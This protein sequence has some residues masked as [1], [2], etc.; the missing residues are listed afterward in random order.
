VVQT[1]CEF[2]AP[3]S[4][5]GSV[6]VGIRVGRIGNSSVRYELGIFNGTQLCAYGHFVHV[7]VDSK[8]RR[9]VSL[10]PALK[11]FLEALV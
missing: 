6:D 7:Y 10:A 3:L 1:H 9:P 4:F 2:C 5:P 8:S 11:T